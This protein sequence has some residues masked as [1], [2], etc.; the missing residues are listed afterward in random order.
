MFN[1]LFSDIIQ[2]DNTARVNFSFGCQRE[3]NLITENTSGFYGNN[4]IKE[5]RKSLCKVIS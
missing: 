2:N 5:T 4:R 3:E 1:L